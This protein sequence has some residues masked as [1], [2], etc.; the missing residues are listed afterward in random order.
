MRNQA[1]TG[2]FCLLFPRSFTSALP[3]PSPWEVLSAVPS[4]IYLSTTGPGYKDP[5]HGTSAEQLRNWTCEVGT[6][7]RARSASGRW[8]YRDQ[9]RHCQTFHLTKTSVLVSKRTSGLLGWR[10]NTEGQKYYLP[11]PRV[12]F[13]VLHFR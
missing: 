3:L 1:N 5:L 13:V 9:G 6:L 8:G 2:P 10:W 11:L 4:R 7:N 12:S